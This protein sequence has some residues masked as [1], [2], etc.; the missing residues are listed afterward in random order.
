MT[1]VGWKARERKWE[2]GN[3]YQYWE[4]TSIPTTPSMLVCP[5]LDREV[6]E[7]INKLYL[8]FLY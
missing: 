4:N 1:A 7:K 5:V 8:D 3:Q 2:R 6:D